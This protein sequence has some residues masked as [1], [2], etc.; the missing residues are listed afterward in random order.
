MSNR[1]TLDDKECRKYCVIWTAKNRNKMQCNAIHHKI[2]K[3]ENTHKEASRRRK[4]GSIDVE[5][6]RLNVRNSYR[7]RLL[8]VEKSGVHDGDATKCTRYFILFLCCVF[9]CSE[10]KFIFYFHLFN[11]IAYMYQAKYWWSIK[12]AKK[13]RLH[14]DEKCSILI[15]FCG[16]LNSGSPTCVCSHF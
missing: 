14:T 8:H 7:S 11:H 12:R 15:T 5:V 10:F 9:M 1:P 13:C 4:T 2:I 3:H 6:Q 16:N